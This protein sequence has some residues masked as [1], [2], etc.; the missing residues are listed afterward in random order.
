LIALF[1][2]YKVIERKAGYLRLCMIN[3]E[4]DQ[5]LK[6]LL[7]LFKNSI[8]PDGCITCDHFTLLDRL[9]KMFY[10]EVFLVEDHILKNLLQS[11]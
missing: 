9:G 1:E 4:K 8:F 2:Q 3:A 5:N 6:S 7:T 11:K 10:G